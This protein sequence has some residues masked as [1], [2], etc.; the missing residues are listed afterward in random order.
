MYGM[1]I[2]MMHLR[3]QV[4][5]RNRVVPIEKTGY[6]CIHRCILHPQAAVE[7]LITQTSRHPYRIVA[8]AIKLQIGYIDRHIGILQATMD[9]PPHRG[10][11]I[12]RADQRLLIQELSQAKIIGRHTSRQHLSGS[13]IGGL[14]IGCG[15]MGHLRI[16]IGH[17]EGGHQGR[18]CIKFGKRP[19]NI[20]RQL[21]LSGT[22]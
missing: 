18:L 20:P 13:R 14:G 8:I 16:E 11:H 6:L 4:V 7:G 10:G 9:Q 19:L 5:A 17:T 12:D 15:P 3:R 21:H 22:L 1:Q 2:H